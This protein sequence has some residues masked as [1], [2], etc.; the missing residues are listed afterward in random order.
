MISMK[1]TLF[2]SIPLLVGVLALSGCSLPG[3]SPSGTGAA[4]MKSA[5]G[6]KTYAPKVTID[7]KT[8]IAPANI[9]S[10]V[11]E[12]GN[13][14]RITVGTR[15]N[16]IFMSENGGDTWKK[17]NFPPTKTYGL[18]A[19]WSR[20]ERLYAAGEWEGRGKLYRSDDRGGKWDEVY[21]EPNTGTVVTALIQH[22]KNASTLYVGTSAGVIIRTTDGGLTWG[23]LPGAETA[24]LSFAFDA[25]GETLYALTSGKGLLRSKN[26]GDSFEAIPGAGSSRRS[27]TL[28]LPKV[29]SLAIDP[30]RSG[31]F[32]AGTEKGLFRSRD[33]G[34]AWEELPVIESSK[35]FSVRAVAINPKN[36][37]EI[38]YS[39]AL[40]IYKS[41]DGG[42]NWSVYQLKA[43]RAAGM[44]KYD[45]SDPNV[46]YLGLRTFN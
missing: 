31:T 13:P 22:P 32:Y 16:G 44:I 29:T 20:P 34:D 39:S 1:K 43:N 46:I 3:T 18:V 26:G 45:S 24:I 35:E 30:S 36:S 7:A 28:S 21:A 27:T 6:G 42:T 4:V 41:I 2:F 38:M 33:F 8:T 10:F 9:L 40:A 14:K 11:F 17:M 5:D 25:G 23:N 37:N 15:E 12:A 19:D